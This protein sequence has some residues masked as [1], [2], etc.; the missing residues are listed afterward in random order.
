MVANGEDDDTLIWALDRILDSQRITPNSL[1]EHVLPAVVPDA[2]ELPDA[3]RAKLCLRLLEADMD[4][5]HLDRN[6]LLMLEQ[7]AACRVEDVA[8]PALV[9]PSREL[10]L[11]VKTEVALQMLRAR[12]VSVPDA[13]RDLEDLFEGDN[14]AEEY[15]RYDRLKAALQSSQLEGEV[16]ALEREFPFQRMMGTVVKFVARA[17]DALPKSLLL[18]IQDDILAGRYVIGEQLVAVGERG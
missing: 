4:E 10:L 13:E 9:C 6:T 18:T 16:K 14:N 7:L 8:N 1:V 11:K 15:E 3:T 5:G 2:A 17:M 12:E